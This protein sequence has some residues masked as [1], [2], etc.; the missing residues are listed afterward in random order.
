MIVEFY[1]FTYA[2]R[3][4]NVQYYWKIAIDTENYNINEFSG[5]DEFKLHN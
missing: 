5:S 2:F 3:T 1:L 4:F